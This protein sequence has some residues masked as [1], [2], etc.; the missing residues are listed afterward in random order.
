MAS[1]AVVSRIV[2][3]LRL[4]ADQPDTPEGDNALRHAQRLMAEHS[5]I[6]V[7]DDNPEDTKPLELSHDFGTF[8]SRELWIDQVSHVVCFL[9]DLAPVWYT[10]P[11]GKVGLLVFDLH[12]DRAQLV[13][14]NKCFRMLFT[15]VETQPLPRRLIHNV[16]PERA[17]AIFR[18][19]V[20][21]SVVTRVS[22]FRITRIDNAEIIM[23]QSTDLVPIRKHYMPRHEHVDP[24]LGVPIQGGPE[25]FEG[26]AEATLFQWGL[27]AGLRAW[28]PDPETPDAD[29]RETHP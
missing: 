19:G 29:D 11:D 24:V 20:A 21:H 18:A 7:L 8:A 9:Y 6:V 26:G 17:K 1:D 27:Q 25:D 4:A 15:F 16:E 28:L 10:T 2:K 12:G 14:A 13:A 23:S 5:V 22:K 3:L